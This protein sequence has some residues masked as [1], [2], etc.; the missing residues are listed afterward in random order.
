V[1]PPSGAA[2]VLSIQERGALDLQSVK[3]QATSRRQAEEYRK[4][5]AEVVFAF[6]SAKLH[7]PRAIFT[8]ARERLI[9][10]RLEECGDDVS[11]LLYA[12]DGVYADDWVMGRSN[13]SVKR[14]DTPEFIFRNWGQV[15]R[16]A[17]SRKGY[18][19]GKPHPLAIKYSL[20]ADR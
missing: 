6:Y 8:P 18:N 11:A 19:E 3:D 7:H 20:V 14:F 17:E 12:I 16:F 13:D 4:R 2:L 10:L 1:T 9:C 5:L 15:E